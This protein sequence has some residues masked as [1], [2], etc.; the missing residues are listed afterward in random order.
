MPDQL[1]VV[2]LERADFDHLSRPGGLDMTLQ[3]RRLLLP[4]EQRA[5]PAA[6][7]GPAHQEGLALA[8]ETRV[9]HPHRVDAQTGHLR[10]AL[11]G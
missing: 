8:Q 10:D 3:Q 6:A 9:Q 7:T 5:A 2:A 1:L 4:V 11:R